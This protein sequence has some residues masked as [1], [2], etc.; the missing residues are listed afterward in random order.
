MKAVNELD[1]L[2]CENKVLMDITDKDIETYLKRNSINVSARSFADLII[3]TWELNFGNNQNTY[4]FH[5]D[6]T[7]EQIHHFKVELQ[8]QLEKQQ[9]E[10]FVLSPM[11]TYM[12]GR[13][14]LRGD[15]LITDLD[16]S[17]A[18]ITSF[19]VDLSNF[20]Q[21]SME[22]VKDSIEI[23][24]DMMKQ[25]LLKEMRHWTLK[26]DYLISFDKSTNT[27]AWRFKETTPAGNNKE[28]SVQLYRK[29]ERD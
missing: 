21:A 3:G 19:E 25:F 1:L 7:L 24:K 14:E 23:K 29:M 6:N 18:A 9:K 13:W 4:L 2:N 22:I 10:V 12:E 26:K 11:T 20:P 17:T 8:F 16:A 27:M 28:K 5:K 15:T